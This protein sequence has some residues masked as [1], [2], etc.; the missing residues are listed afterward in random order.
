MLDISNP[1]PEPEAGIIA[2]LV[3]FLFG[4]LVY[5]DYVAHPF[6]TRLKICRRCGKKAIFP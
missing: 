6:S 3:C 4:H 5:D 2:R 1:N